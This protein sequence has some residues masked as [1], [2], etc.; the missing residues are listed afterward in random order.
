MIKS[1]A[2]ILAKLK[3]TARITNRSYQ[4]CLQLFCQEEFL[5]KLESSKYSDNFILKGGYLVYLITNYD[6]RVTYDIDFLLQKLPSSPEDIKK[7]IE[8]I[9]Y[10]YI[11]ESYIKFEFKST[12]SILISNDYPGI[13][14]KLEAK[15]GNTIT[16]FSIDFGIN[17]VIVPHA[18]KRSIS[19][20]LDGFRSPEIYTYSIESII[21]EKLD[22]IL[23]WMEY[24]SRMK[25]Y[26]DLYF[27]FQRYDFNSLML[28]EAITQTFE[29][30]KRSFSLG[31]FEVVA[32]FGN[33]KNMNLKWE[34]FLK[35][36]KI[37]EI[38]FI[39]VITLIMKFLNVPYKN[40]VYN[41]DNDLHWSAKEQKWLK[42]K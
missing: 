24:T 10:T 40:Y 34:K 31:E 35:K 4:L 30:R 36:I 41:M 42:A 23:H 2:S 29:N 20:Q 16:P 25:D 33:D 32:N 11:K 1:D 12:E 22:A 21:A 39:E 38:E 28:T 17:D 37:K 13:K 8:E 14:V 9:I 19:T 15:I 6:S 26:Y 27:L 5:R 3:N 18:E 7:I